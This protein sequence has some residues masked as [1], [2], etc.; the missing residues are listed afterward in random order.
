MT[1]TTRAQRVALKA[2]YDRGPIMVDE[3]MPY[4]M[5]TLRVRQSYR[6]FRKTVQPTFGMD[7]AVTVLWCNMWLAVETDGYVHS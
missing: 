4:T 7:G 1:R 2:I 5:K 6:G 3:Y